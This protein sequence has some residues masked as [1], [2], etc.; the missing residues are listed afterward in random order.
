MRDCVFCRIAA[1]GKAP[2]SIVYEDEL[3]LVSPP[4]QPLNKGRLLVVP[5]NH[6]ESLADI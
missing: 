4:L 1:A 2:A 3:V 6:G 5:K